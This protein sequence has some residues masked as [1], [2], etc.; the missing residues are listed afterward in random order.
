MR[1]LK[2]ILRLQQDAGALAL[3]A[4]GSAAKDVVAA[5]S[6]P[7]LRFSN[8][9]PNSIDHTPLLSTLPE[10][11]VCVT[12]CNMRKLNASSE[13]NCSAESFSS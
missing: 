5:D 9:L 7:F 1:S 13:E 11:R 12:A 10:T 2:Q 3:R 8:P 4:F 6:N